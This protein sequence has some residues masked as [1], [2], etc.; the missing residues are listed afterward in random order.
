MVPFWRPLQISIFLAKG[1]EEII[2]SL[3][4]KIINLKVKGGCKGRI[5]FTFEWNGL[6]VTIS[7]K[8]QVWNPE[9]GIMIESNFGK[10][11]HRHNR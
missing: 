9:E 1:N 2:N 10:Y 7:T 3:I 8:M 4:K 5:G 11:L 6:E